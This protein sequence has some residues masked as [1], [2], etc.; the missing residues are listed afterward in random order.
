MSP[1]AVAASLVR[2]WEG[3][4]LTAYPDPATGADPWTIGYGAT[5]PGIRKGVTW[6][7]AQADQRLEHDV[8][9]FVDGVLVFLKRPATDN[10]LGAMASLAYNIGLRRF[11]ESTLLRLFNEG[12]TLAA[13]Q[14]FNVWTMAAGKRMQGLVNR[15]ADERRVFET[16]AT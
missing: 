7:Q 2:K 12:K 13:G 9:R 5:G 15:R 6:T 11:S 14:Q 3:C 16:A 4:R 8:S 1:I 10:Q